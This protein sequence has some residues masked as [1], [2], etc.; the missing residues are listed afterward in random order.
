MTIENMKGMRNWVAWK[1]HKRDGKT[2][3]LPINPKTGGNAMP[4]NPD[5]WSDY[6][7]ADKYAKE[8]RL[9]SGNNGVPF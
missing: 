6:Q 1:K 5:T 8:K 4:N 3:K 9:D 2:T 7:T